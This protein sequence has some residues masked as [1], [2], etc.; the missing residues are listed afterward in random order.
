MHAGAKN[1]IFYLFLPSLCAD[2][3]HSD[4][5]QKDRVGKLLDLLGFFGF[6]SRTM[7]GKSVKI[8]LSGVSVIESVRSQSTPPYKQLDLLLKCG[9]FFM[10]FLFW[11]FSFSLIH[12]TLQP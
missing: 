3:C 9:F 12:A 2:W 1:A 8:Y 5:V 7:N 11:F 4:L 6:S 10:L